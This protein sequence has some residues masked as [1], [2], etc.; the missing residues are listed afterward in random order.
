[1][2]LDVI[3]DK[4]LANN[5][6]TY[7]VPA[8]VKEKRFHNWL[9]DARDWNI[10]RNRYWGTPIPIWMS[11]DGE[12]VVVIGSIEELERLTGAKIT[13]LH[14][15]NIDHL[16]IP[17][18]KGKG[19][20]RRV[21]EVFDCW[22]ESGSMPYAQQHYPFE[23]KERFEKS[24]PADFVAEGLDQTRG[25]FYTLMVLSTALFDKPAFK[26]LIVNGMVLAADGKKMSKRLKNYPDPM[27]VV[28]SYGADA[29]R[30]YLI[31]S[32]VVRAEVLKFQ[33]EG[34]LQNLK[35]IFIPWF[36]AYRFFVQ[37]ALRAETT[38]T[39]AFNRAGAATA[40]ANSSNIM[41]RWIL[42]ATHG[43]IRFVRQ[44][45][46]AYRLYTVVPRLV[47]FVER[48]CNCYVRFNR[49]RING[50]DK[51][52]S[53][54]T[55][56]GLATLY[57]V[58]L[59]LAKVMAP[60]TPFFADY[61]Y[62]KLARPTTE[63][64]DSV[65]F[66][67]MPEVDESLIDPEIETAMSNMLEVI[68]LGRLARGND[69][70]LK[71]PL[72]ELIVVHESQSVLDRLQQL[73][74]YIK[75]EL[76]VHKVTFT[77]DEPTY[78]KLSAKVNG[79]YE[80]D[81]V[82]VGQRLGKKMATIGKAVQQL[83]HQEL[84]AFQKEGT[85]TIEGETLSINEVFL[86]RA[87]VVD[88]EK[89]SA[90]V[91]LTANITVVLDTYVDKKLLG[92]QTAREVTNRV[93]KLRKASGVQVGDVLD[94]FYRA[95]GS[96]EAVAEVDEAVVDNADFIASSLRSALHNASLRPVYAQVVGETTE[97]LGD[98]QLT[99]SLCIP[100]VALP[101]D[102]KLAELLN[103]D[104]KLA[105]GVVATVA[106]MDTAWLAQHAASSLELTVD[107]KLLKLERGTHFFLSVAE[108]ADK[109]K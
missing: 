71:R 44:E 102:E 20:L 48:L 88:T 66:L 10:S 47:E 64:E 75:L 18:Q 92:E 3:K 13:D 59:T 89:Y 31:N 4:L 25:W 38:H 9:R 42:A 2:R 51:E 39:T 87:A 81:G 97:S 46:A 74:S 82:K 52:A 26:N 76:N 17:S 83:S 93:Q 79:S 54:D 29:L 86:N 57:T 5:D 107:G 62:R 50:E 8:N 98:V 72:R 108:K 33:E 105:K 91:S 63:R 27:E 19:V 109:S 34:V 70:P 106:S 100:A 35:E 61:L 77:N 15:E 7:W 78:C 58:L 99:L 95:T 45:M 22:F 67:L 16:E 14:R 85:I 30:L 53:A 32:P 60:F 12:E 84:S 65:H 96:A 80:T 49:K 40:A 28:H 37:N 1:V 36:N 103:V 73:E 69:L 55:D 68:N 90:Q 41:D 11:D 21:P 43:L 24:F 104:I 6:K 23:N 94:V 56:T 101:A